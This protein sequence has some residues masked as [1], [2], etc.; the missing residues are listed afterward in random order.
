MAVP[1]MKSVATDRLFPHKSADPRVRMAAFERRTQKYP[2]A[3]PGGT[4]ATGLM[5]GDSRGYSELLGEQRQY[6]DDGQAVRGR[7]PMNVE[8]GGDANW[9]EATGGRRGG[10]GG[11]RQSRLDMLSRTPS[12]PRAPQPTQ[13]PTDPISVLGPRRDPDAPVYPPAD[14]QDMS[15]GGGVSSRGVR[16][17][18]VTA[19]AGATGRAGAYGDNDVPQLM[20][21][22]RTR[23]VGNERRDTL[24]GAETAA[25]AN[26][27]PSAVRSRTEATA[28]Q[29]LLARI[30]AQGTV[31]AAT[32]R[33]RGDVDAA[34]LRQPTTKAP[35][36]TDDFKL[37]LDKFGPDERGNW[38]PPP[39]DP[40]AR[41]IYDAFRSR[42]LSAQ[43]TAG[44]PDLD[45]GGGDDDDL[46]DDE[47][48]D[49][50]VSQK[51]YTEQQARAYLASQP[52]GGQ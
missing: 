29:E 18:S 46:S 38:A 2:G 41:E 48:I 22:I 39:T 34:R 40:A 12:M 33:A 52:G 23:R 28:V 15:V 5:S 8:Y 47:A 6:L 13:Q 37:F 9:V 7:G 11:G 16:G 20:E 25:A 45:M 43:R 50:L 27:V 3:A 44:A 4:G 31:D 17:G 30:R 10:I 35:D 32:A 14:F 36:Q 19:A 26:F 24:E 21:D 49:Y 1:M 42:L 51:G